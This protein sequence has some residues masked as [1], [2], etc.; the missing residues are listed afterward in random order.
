MKADRIQTR[1][2]GIP[3]WQLVGHQAILKT[4]ELPSFRAAMAFA[5]YVAELA[6]AVGHYPDI[7]VSREQ[8]TLSLTTPEKGRP[9]RRD[10]ELAA[11]IDRR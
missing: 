10:F 4:Y 5:F 3:G 1:L 11:A 8:V 2:G 7:L 6:E 9:T